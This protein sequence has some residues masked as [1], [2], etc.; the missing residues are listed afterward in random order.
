MTTPVKSEIH[1]IY[2]KCQKN[3]RKV[4]KKDSKISSEDCYKFH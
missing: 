2:Y 4:T 1:K 3:D